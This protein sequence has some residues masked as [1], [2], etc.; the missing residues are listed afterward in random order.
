MR[1]LD[2]GEG[3]ARATMTVRPDMLNALGSLHG[4]VFF[5]FA[6]S[7]FGVAC[8]WHG[9]ATFGMSCDATYLAPAYPK[10]AL[11]A[12]AREVHRAGRTSYF[13]VTVSRDDGT[14]LLLFHGTSRTPGA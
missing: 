3:F 9:K 14:V 6:D 8:N 10:D 4:G 13:D 5:T 1:L 2:A 11:I 7:T 12:E